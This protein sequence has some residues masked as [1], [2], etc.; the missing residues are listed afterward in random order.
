M[1]TKGLEYI[2]NYKSLSSGTYEV[3][4]HID[5]EFF[6]M[7]PDGEIQDGDVDVNVRFKV[8]LAAIVFKFTFNGTLSVSCDRCLEVFDMPIKAQYDMVAKIG[9]KSSAPSEADD[10]I[11]L[12]MNE[13][14]IDLK[15]H[16]YEYAVLSLPPRRVHPNDKNGDP[17]CNPEMLKHFSIVD[18]GDDD[19]EYLDDEDFYDDEDL[20]DEDI[21]FSDEDFAALEAEVKK[22]R[23]E[24]PDDFS[25]ED[26]I[27]DDELYD[28][29]DGLDES[30]DQGEEMETI[31]QKL[32][33]DPNWAKLKQL[34]TK[35]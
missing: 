16:I 25:D 21:D 30:D 35:Q 7:F 2:I 9:E 32:S 34:L 33:R 5:R 26:D 6:E 15:Q 1:A 28:D 18:D 12:S 29:E 14:E 20:D 4:Y 13:E 3:D 31:E 8:S 22:F 24:N 11:E 10:Y 27:D 23:A 19:D 17:T